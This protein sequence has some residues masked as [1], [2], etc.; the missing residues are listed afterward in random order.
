MIGNDQ[1][2]H[3]KPEFAPALLIFKT[4]DDEITSNLDGAY[5]EIDEKNVP[6]GAHVITAHIIYKIRT[7]KR[8]TS[9]E[10]GTLSTRK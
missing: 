9:S 7:E 6:Q 8:E 3:K 2:T 5:T 4:I 1:A 10:S